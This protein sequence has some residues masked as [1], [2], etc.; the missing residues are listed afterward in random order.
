MY[1]DILIQTDGSNT[2]DYAAA[3]GLSL[4][5]QYG[6]TVHVLFV[7][8]TDVILLK[9]DDGHDEAT[10]QAAL[11]KRGERV[12][13]AIGERARDECLHVTTDVREGRPAEEIRRYAEENEIDLIAMGTHGKS[14]IDRFLI[15]SVTRDVLRGG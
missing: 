13:D 1:T 4:A 6:A 2:A 12:T 10:L 7:I 11:R 3:H 15:G 5:K 9:L 14:K 8:N